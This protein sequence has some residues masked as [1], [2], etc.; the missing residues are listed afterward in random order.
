MN[1]KHRTK[2]VECRT[3]SAEP[4]A[5]SHGFSLT[6]ILIAIG[7]L[8]VGMIF[9]AGVFPVGIHLTT[10]ATERTIAA[11]AADEAFA[12]IRIYAEGDPD[13]SFDDVV[14]SGLSRTALADFN[15][16]SVF[17]ATA[18]GNID[19][20]EF[21]Y[22]S[23]P[24]INVSD[25]QYFWSALCR[26]TEN[27][28]TNPNPPVQVT[29]F[30]CRRISPNMQY[31]TPSGSDDGDRPVPVKVDVTEVTGKDNELSI[32]DPN[33]ITFINDGYRIVD[34]ATGRIY[35]VLERYR[36]IPNTI[37]LDKDWDNTDW[38]GSPISLPKVWVVPPPVSGGL[39]PC[40]AIYQK[41]ISF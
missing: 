9:I 4:R 19:A 10:I 28:A 39:G 1:K 12:K 24:E 40:I 17:P 23:D 22:P 36:E 14:L 5:T 3:T 31:R 35:R 13:D 32:N 18:T 7:I 26:L 8:S 37:L 21:A 11:V 41:V 2:N 25:K 16:P 29:V 33:K 6:E 15:D 20:D 30:V 27:L 34:D 38:Q